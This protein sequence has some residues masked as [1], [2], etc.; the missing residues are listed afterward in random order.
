MVPKPKLLSSSTSGSDDLDKLYEMFEE[1]V[2]DTLEF[3]IDRENFKGHLLDV[4]M[5]ETRSGDPIGLLLTV[6]RPLEGEV[7]IDTSFK[8]DWKDTDYIDDL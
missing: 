2:G 7:T 3:Y 5:R 1:R 8:G 6:E 4:E